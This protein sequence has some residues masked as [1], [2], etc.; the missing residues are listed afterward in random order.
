MDGYSPRV[1]ESRTGLSRHVDNSVT[2]TTAT[3]EF[4]PFLLSE[5]GGHAGGETGAPGAFHVGE[6]TRRP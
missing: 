3:V 1:T 6:V 4:L 2:V 5:G